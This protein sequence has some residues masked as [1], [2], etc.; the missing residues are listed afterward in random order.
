MLGGRLGDFSLLLFP[1]DLLR[2]LNTVTLTVSKGGGLEGTLPSLTVFSVGCEIAS[3]VVFVTDSESVLHVGG[4]AGGPGRT[5]EGGRCGED[6]L[7]RLQF[8]SDIGE[9]WTGGGGGGKL[10]GAN[11]GGRLGE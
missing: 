9:V 7:E 5:I 10:G 6:V 8:S 11:D 1:C 4:L 2:S 3:W